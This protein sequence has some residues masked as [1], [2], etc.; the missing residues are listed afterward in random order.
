MGAVAALAVEQ[1]QHTA[2]MAASGNTAAAP[3]ARI[4]R[5][6]RRAADG[7]YASA[8]TS[9]EAAAAQWQSMLHPEPF[10]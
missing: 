2:M 3:M 1:Q 10:R 9:Q 8:V 4:Y 6:G 5:T 7:S